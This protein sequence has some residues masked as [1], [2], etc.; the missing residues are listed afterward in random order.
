[1]YGPILAMLMPD[2]AE[3]VGFE[4]VNF[5]L[6]H[7]VLFALPVVWMAR[8]RFHI[9]SIGAANVVASWAVF[10]IVHGAVLTP[11]SI[12]S[13]RNIDYMMVRHHRASRMLELRLP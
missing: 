13:G 1:M 11:W 10:F 2:N 5:W 9:Y 8:R 6:E 4:N 3:N 7:G 12:L